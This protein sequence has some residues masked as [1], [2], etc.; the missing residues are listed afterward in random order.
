MTFTDL[1]STTQPDEFSPD[2]YT[3]E[4]QLMLSRIDEAEDILG[5]TPPRALDYPAIFDKKL[6][7]LIDKVTL[8]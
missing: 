2:M 8:E 1:A 4:N 5:I 3:G 7:E 6:S